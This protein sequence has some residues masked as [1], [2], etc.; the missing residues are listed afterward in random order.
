[1]LEELGWNSYF[2]AV[3]HE[4]EQPSG[5][6]GRV[7][8]QH[9]GLWRVVLE[10]GE[11]DAEMSGKMRFAAE[12]SGMWPTVGDWVAI[13]GNPQGRV[14]INATLPR[15]T[16]IVRKTA[17]R[18]VEQQVLAANV[19]VAWLVM[20]LDGDYNPRRL[21]RYLAQ[22]W[23]AGVRPMVILNKRDLCSEVDLRI[24][25]V[26]QLAFGAPV[27]AVSAATGEGMG[28]LARTLRAGTSLV[29]LGSSGTGKSTLTNQLMHMDLQATQAV[30]TGDSRGRHTTT[31]RQ[32]FMLPTGA[33]LIDTPGLRELQLWDASDG[34]VRTFAD[35][36]EFATHCRFD[37]CL[38]QGEPD[39]AVQAAVEQGDLPLGRLENYRKLKR[40]QEFLRRKIDPEARAREKKTLKSV[41][42]AVRQLYQRRE[43]EGR[44]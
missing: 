14:R 33:M 27:F 1:M 12:E 44:M 42:R 21:E 37:D 41:G 7:I 6:P 25:E 2:E 18:K 16:A 36:Q 9:R 38:H 28:A 13:E 43:K 10:C 5:E 29:L 32:L 40:E 24:A 4:L 8:E 39:C 30:R 20:G 17:G 35:V 11:A 15:R 26:E 34:L 3:W 31:S 22:A 23:D 19:D